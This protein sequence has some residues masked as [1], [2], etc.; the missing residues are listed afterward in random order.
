MIATKRCGPT[1]T[2]LAFAA[3][4]LLTSSQTKAG[5]IHPGAKAEPFLTPDVMQVASKNQVT[6]KRRISH[7][8][9]LAICRERRGRGNVSRVTIRKD[10]SFVCHAPFIRR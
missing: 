6:R 3:M 9:A 1:I 2:C 5:V 4:A 7:L 8:E 10:G